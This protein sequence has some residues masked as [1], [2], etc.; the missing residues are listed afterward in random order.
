MDYI[1]KPN[2]KFQSETA[3]ITVGQTQPLLYKNLELHP[4]KLMQENMLV[5]AEK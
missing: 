3:S 4:T 5:N 1:H 2:P